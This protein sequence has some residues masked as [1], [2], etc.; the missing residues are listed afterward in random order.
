MQPG[1]TRLGQP[2]GRPWLR[3]TQRAVAFHLSAPAGCRPFFRCPLSRQSPT[4][5]H[6]SSKDGKYGWL[7]PVPRSRLTPSREACKRPHG[8]PWDMGASQPTP[9]CCCEE[10]RTPTT[11]PRPAGPPRGGMRG[12]GRAPPAAAGD[13]RA[14]STYPGAR[15]R[16]WVARR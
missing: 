16:T 15:V 3:R 11:P 2:P 13:G 4:G 10:K 5:A 1:A 9:F 6:C 8:C 7:P 14:R 12:P